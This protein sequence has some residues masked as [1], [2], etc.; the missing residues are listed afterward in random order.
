LIYW[1]LALPA[2]GDRIAAAAFELPGLR[3]T[4]LR[5][6]EPLHAPGADESEL[7]SARLP[8]SGGVALGFAQTSVLV[9]GHPILHELEL[10]IGAG[11]HVAVVGRSG[12]GKSSL[13]GLLLGWHRAHSGAVTVDGGPLDVAAL[14]QVTAWVDP[15]V[16]LWNRTLLENLRYGNPDAQQ[17]ADALTRAD[18]QT[19]LERL[20][21]GLQTALGEGGGLVSGGEGQRVRLARAL[22]RPA[23][24]LVLLDEPFR[25]LDRPARAELMT[26]ARAAWHGATLLCVTHDIDAARGFAR[27]LVIEGGRIVED[28]DPRELAE[29]EGSQLRA[30]LDAERELTANGWGDKA[31]RRLALERGELREEVEA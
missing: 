10:E 29:R 6:V 1:A 11:E 16:Q 7:E 9:G 20:P 21:D 8:G 13:I 22:L 31:W 4:A 18:L 30:L 17:L 5:L 14:R 23:P 12:A 15:A 19:T 28:G 27:V 26:R 3:N 2:I 25:G 24:R